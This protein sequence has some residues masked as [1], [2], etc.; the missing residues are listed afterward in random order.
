[1]LSDHFDIIQKIFFYSVLATLIFGTS[2]L[3]TGFV[4]CSAR[5]NEIFNCIPY[6]VTITGQLG[7]FLTLYGICH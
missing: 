5:L 7:H 6:E 2:C 3:A 4:T 1:M